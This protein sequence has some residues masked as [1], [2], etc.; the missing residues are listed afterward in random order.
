MKGEAFVLGRVW[1]GWSERIGPRLRE[2][3]G[4]FSV[5]ERR[6]DVMILFLGG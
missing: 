2:E 4:P 6:G 5:G 1:I 3:D